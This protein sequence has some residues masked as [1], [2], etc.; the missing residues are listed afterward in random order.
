M[1]YVLF[2]CGVNHQHRKVNTDIQLSAN[3]NMG[4]K[5]EFHPDAGGARGHAS[6]EILVN[7]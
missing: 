7:R 3:N 4:T 5:V 1:E 6:R 2:R